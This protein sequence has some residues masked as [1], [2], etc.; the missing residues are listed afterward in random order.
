MKLLVLGAA[1]QVGRE[2]CRLAWPAGYQLAAFDRDGVD[3]TRREAVAAAVARERPDIVVNAAAYPAVDR[4]E[5]ETNKAWA[6]NCTGPLNLAA[7]CHAAAIPLLHL[8]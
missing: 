7:C 1:G 2:L 5:V 6:D 4:A 3:I 8:S